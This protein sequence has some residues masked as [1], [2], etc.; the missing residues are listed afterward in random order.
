MGDPMNAYELAH[1]RDIA[2]HNAAVS[3]AIDDAMKDLSKRYQTVK[4][5][6]FSAVLEKRLAELHDQLLAD[7]TAGIRNQWAISN[8]KTNVML[9]GYLASVKISDAMQKSFRAPNLSALDAFLDRKAAG[10]NLSDRVWKV[11]EGVRGEIENIIAKGVLEGK[12]SVKMA[13]ELQGY[14]SGE[15]IRY[16]GKL[17]PGKNLT[18]QAIRLTAN[19]M[20]MAFRTADYLQNS[21][22]PFVTGVTVELSASHPENDICDS[23]VGEYPKGYSFTGFHPL[24][25]CIATYNTIPSDDFVKYLQTGEMDTTKFTTDAPPQARLFIEKNG[26]RLLKYKNPPY[27]LEN[28]TKNLTLKKSVSK[29]N[30]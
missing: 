21:R 1:I 8:K 10:M 17:I 13:K 23:L 16:A 12:S 26:P 22:L 3:Q 5:R 18:Y 6:R 29:I 28:Y 7:S 30:V 19:E 15:P 4:G 25:I 24:C 27:F 14:I 2:R 9:D 11:T 20:N